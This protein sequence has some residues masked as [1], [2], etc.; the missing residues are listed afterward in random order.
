MNQNDDDTMLGCHHNMSGPRCADCVAADARRAPLRTYAA[1]VSIAARRYPDGTITRHGDRD[2]VRNAAGDHVGTID[3]DGHAQFFAVPDNR[4]ATAPVPTWDEAIDAFI[5]R[6]LGFPDDDTRRPN[7]ARTVIDRAVQ[8][9]AD[10]DRAFA[11][12]SH[13]PGIPEPTV[14]QFPDFMAAALPGQPDPDD[15]DDDTPGPT[16][17][18]V[19]AFIDWLTDENYPPAP[20]TVSD[21]IDRLQDRAAQHGRAAAYITYPAD[22]TL[23]WRTRP[24]GADPELAALED[25]VTTLNNTAPDDPARQRIIGYLERRPGTT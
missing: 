1:A 7:V 12:I 16:W 23:E 18:T 10:N 9:A 4:D 2:T 5:D 24:T 17:D 6:A 8:R 20:D 14:M 3:A 21:L 19:D 11:V 13:P 22:R 15:D 25:I